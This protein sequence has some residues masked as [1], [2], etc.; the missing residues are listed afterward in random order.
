MIVHDGSHRFQFHDQLILDEEIRVKLPQQ[1]VVFIQ[2]AQWMLLGDPKSPLA[3]TM[4][5]CVLIDLFQMPVPV[6]AVYGKPGFTND[7][8]QLKNRIFL[9]HVLVDSVFAP[10]APLCGYPRHPWLSR[11]WIIAARMSFQVC[12][13]RRVSLAN[14][15][16][17]QQMC[18]VLRV[19]FP[20]S[21]RSQ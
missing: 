11:T 13:F 19:T 15:Q 10:L 21:S 5:Q 20:A 1:G 17:S 8:T 3:Q 6:I 2:D 9:F 12:C 16:P 14:M 7:V 4:H 18:L